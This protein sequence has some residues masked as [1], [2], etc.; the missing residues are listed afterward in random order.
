M[1]EREFQSLLRVACRMEAADLVGVEPGAGN[2]ARRIRRLHTAVYC[3]AAALA[4]C[5]A[6]SF[7]ARPTA[8]VDSGPQVRAEP[9]RPLLPA[10]RLL[11]AGAQPVHL[12]SVLEQGGVL[13]AL[14]GA[15]NSDCECIRW[16]VHEWSDGCATADVANNQTVN[17]PI[18]E[19]ATDQLVLFAV[20]RRADDLPRD[21][22]EA[23]PLLECLNRL[24][25]ADPVETMLHNSTELAAACL[26]DG[27][28][29]SSQMIPTR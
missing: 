2:V 23:Q 11:Q 21:A 9:T 16:R 27:V 13:L 8:A 19:T 24:D 17:I 7:V 15:W 4:A 12:A 5:L 1:T 26:P 20:A 3:A 22:D 6:L 18:G 10:H 14:L 25:E 29:L 28:H